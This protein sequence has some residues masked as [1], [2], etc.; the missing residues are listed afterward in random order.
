MRRITITM[1]LAIVGMAVGAAAFSGIAKLQTERHLGR[2][3]WM[4]VQDQFFTDLEGKTEKLDEIISGY[5]SD[6]SWRQK[7]ISLQDGKMACTRT[8][9]LVPG[10]GTFL[11]DRFHRRLSFI[12]EST[13]RSTSSIDLPTGYF[14]SEAG[15][16]GDETIM[17]Y[18][19]AHF[20][21]RSGDGS[22]EDRWYAYNFGGE[23]LKS[24]VRHDDGTYVL[25]PREIKLGEPPADVM[26][27]HSE[28]PIDYRQFEE[29]IK[30]VEAMDPA[31]AE[32]L[33]EA[34]NRLKTM[35]EP[36]N[37]AR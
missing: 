4:L 10:L 28:W 14:R 11:E 24:I 1:M 34:M 21:N 32:K 2:G 35:Q 31:R 36:T 5:G 9:A 3:G 16:V 8:I 26:N 20:L 30:R 17:G 6:G 27:Y 18:K 25:D 15:Y 23:Q 7:T 29:R 13:T 33:K 37:K 22:I 19:C 12:S